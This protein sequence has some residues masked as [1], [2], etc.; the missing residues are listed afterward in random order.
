MNHYLQT[1][2]VESKDGV[3]FAVATASFQAAAFERAYAAKTLAAELAKNS[4]FTRVKSLDDLLPPEE[5]VVAPRIA[6][7]AERRA[8]FRVI[9]GGKS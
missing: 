7:P 1:V 2:L 6:G 8:A 9:K 5:Y 3:T 4:D